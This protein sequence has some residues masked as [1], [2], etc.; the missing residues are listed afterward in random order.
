MAN[1]ITVADVQTHLRLGPLDAAETAE[2]ERM[3]GAAT[4]QAEAF[5]NQ[6]FTDGTVEVVYDRLPATPRMGLVINTNTAG[7]PTV[8]YYDTAN[9][10]QTVASVRYVRR[11]GRTIVYPAFGGEWPS[12]CNNEV[13]SVTVTATTDVTAIPETVKAAILL[14]VGDLYENRE[15]SV[16]GQGI[17]HVRMSLTAERLLTPYKTRA[18]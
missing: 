3:I 2:I 15:Q 7:A 18:A 1:P 9:T 12:D 8:T 4:E 14:I 17:T 13:G 16:T 6:P 5:C 10:E 11:G